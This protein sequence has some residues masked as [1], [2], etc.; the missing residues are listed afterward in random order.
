MSKE[1]LAQLSAQAAQRGKVRHLMPT[2]PRLPRAGAPAID[3]Q[4][5]DQS[6]VGAIFGSVIRK[7]IFAA[8]AGAIAVFIISDQ[9]ELQDSLGDQVL[10]A[11]WYLA[12]V[13]APA[14]LPE[15]AAAIDANGIYDALKPNAGL[16]PFLVPL[17]FGVVVTVLFLPSINAR[18]RGSGARFIVFLAN[19]ALLW[20]AWRANA[21]AVDLSG[22]KDWI[23]TDFHQPGAG[24]RLAGAA[25]DQLRRRPAAAE[26]APEAAGPGPAGTRFRRSSGRPET[27]PCRLGRH[28]QCQP[29]ADDA[30]APQRLAD[31]ALGE[32]RNLAA[33]ALKSAA[34]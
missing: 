32:R 19:L 24:C 7:S 9:Q 8:I 27:E 17:G 11:I 4:A 31:P 23:D 29:G 2:P 28:P 5:S 25:A 6:F 26:H 22:T 12:A 18:R 10:Y 30:P 15:S 20:F 14:L 33:A 34:C 21:A 16:L 1:W 13:A 3:R